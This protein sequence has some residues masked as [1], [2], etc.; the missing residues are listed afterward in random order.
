MLGLATVTLVASAVLVS[1]VPG[2]IA[3]A[4]DNG[5][6][7]VISVLA[8]VVMW[9]TLRHGSR[10]ASWVARGMLVALTL[11]VAGMILWDTQPGWSTASAGPTGA[12]FVGAFA[13]AALTLGWSLAGSV[14]RSRLVPVL[15]D[16]TVIAAASI[17][18]L[19]GAW[20]TPIGQGV[21][22]PEAL[23]A[24]VGAV[25]AISALGAGYLILLHCRV[26]PSF[27]NAYGVLGAISLIGV[28]W[29]AW[30]AA[31]DNGTVGVA[32]TDFAF[33]AGVIL[34]AYGVATWD[35]S[36]ST[37]ERSETL[38]RA[39]VDLFPPV[40]VAICVTLS[41]VSSGSSGFDLVRIGTLFVVGLTLIRQI[42]LS[43]RERH[44]RLAERAASAR[45]AREVAERATVLSALSKLEVSGGPE[46]AA[47]AICQQALM[48]DGVENAVL[49]VFRHDGDAVVIAVR[50]LSD[51]PGMV[52]TVLTASRTE[53]L[54]ARAGS[55]PWSEAYESTDDPHMERLRRTGLRSSYNVPL[56]WNQE[57]LGV[58]GLGSVSLSCLEVPAERA[59]TVHEFALVAGAVLGPPLAERARLEA[60]RT[61]ILTIISERAF[62]PVF[63]AIVDITTAR[64]VGYEALTRFESGQRPD[65]QFGEAD[66]AGLGIELETACLRASID[67]SVDLPADTWLSLNVSPALA[68]AQAPL[69]ELL[70]HGERP[71]VIEITEHVVI[72]NYEGLARA[73]QA[74]RR[75]VRLAIDDAGSGYAGLS[76]ILELRPDILKLDIALVRSVNTDPGRHALVASMVAFA[77][78]THCTVLAE[79]IETTGEL[80]SLRALGV[81]LGQGYLLARPASIGQICSS[82]DQAASPD[83]GASAQLTPTGV[84]PVSWTVMPHPSAIAAAER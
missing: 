48:L 71:I 16:A 14:E 15:L 19:G 13:T 49:R 40:T 12:L 11:A 55:G 68:L 34:L 63:Q 79:G 28:S 25:F 17:T 2:S 24:L 36:P 51:V 74:V 46:E 41:L 26:R 67:A 54:W 69:A 60:I 61:R 72:D 64:V 62:H 45:I 81:E 38:V 29:I 80:E 18:V 52:G 1:I 66:E 3:L 6:Q 35:L 75:Y 47:D 4:I 50:G 58:V 8:V 30:M 78:E 21:G 22:G 37:T 20:A 65:L 32:P 43:I 31:P 33:S 23:I 10:E 77:R 56:Y 7:L 44:S 76:H 73:L 9:A 59:T 70:I 27:G 57:L 84:A 42:L 5:Q 83:I 53:H 39:T 82:T